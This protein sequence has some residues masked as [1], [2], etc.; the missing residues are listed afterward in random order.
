M[1]G[2]GGGERASK[3]RRRRSPAG[4]VGAAA[5]SGSPA[6][7]FP[8]ESAIVVPPSSSSVFHKS[9]H[10]SLVRGR[11][12]FGSPGA[13]LTRLIDDPAYR[14]KFGYAPVLAGLSAERSTSLFLREWMRDRDDV[15]MFDS[16][17]VKGY[18]RA[19]VD[20]DGQ[21]DEG[22]T[23]HVLVCGGDVVLVDTKRWKSRRK[24]SVSKGGSVLRSGKPFGGG[25]LGMRGAMGIW[26][27]YMPRFRVS[28][29]VCVNAPRTFVVYDANW[30]RQPF[31]LVVFDQLGDF[32]SRW[33]DRAHD[34]IRSLAP[35]D[36][37]TAARVCRACVKPYNAF[38]ELFGGDPS[39]V[40]LV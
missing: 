38:R 24:Y 1:T 36:C 15:L 5:H 37:D 10:G 22:D 16:V 35:V 6:L 3:G 11:R 17:H 21:V 39:E 20:E 8:G 7:S 26:R 33:Y 4:P 18:G 25:R 9:V 19:R 28:G 23:D 32:L 31:R 27:S 40:G 30:K 13:A 29:I 34:G 12:R 2:H 14:N